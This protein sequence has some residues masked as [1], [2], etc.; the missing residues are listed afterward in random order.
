MAE[1]HMS[2]YGHSLENA[3]YGPQLTPADE[4]Y[5]TSAC[6]LIHLRQNRDSD[7]YGP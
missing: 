6:H 3:G 5:V 4:S 1:S 7:Y 2:Q